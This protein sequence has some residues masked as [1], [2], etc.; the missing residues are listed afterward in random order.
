[1]S[2]ARRAQLIVAHDIGETI[3][4]LD[5]AAKVAETKMVW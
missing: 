2:P 4:K 3:D 5:A 1:M